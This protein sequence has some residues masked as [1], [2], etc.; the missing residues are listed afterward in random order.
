MGMTNALGFAEAVAEGQTSLLT[1]L[2]WHLTSNHY[3]PLPAAYV[4]PLYTALVLV[5]N[6]LPGDTV[7][8]PEGIQPVPGRAFENDE[9]VLVV[10][11]ADLVEACN[12]WAF[13]PEE[14]Q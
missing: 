3:P 2:G 5:A 7:E 6:N 12:A 10:T 9:G 14:D 11:A 4:E 13:L 1:A 8:V